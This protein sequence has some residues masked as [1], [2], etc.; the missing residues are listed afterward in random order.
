MITIESLYFSYTDG[1]PWV[2]ADLDLH[3]ASG[4]YISVVGENGSG[5]TTLMRLILGFLRPNHGTVAIDNETV[6]YVPQRQEDENRGFP[7]TV[8]ELMTSFRKIRKLPA[9]AVTPALEA[10]GMAHTR[11][12]RVGDLSGGQHQ[13]IKIA[14]ALLGRPQ[15]LIL[16]E[17]STGIDPGSQK[18]IYGLLNRLNRERG[19]T[20]LSVEHNLDA[21]IANSTAIYHLANGHGHLCSPTQFLQEMKTPGFLAAQADTG[22]SPGPTD[23]SSQTGASADRSADRPADRTADRTGTPADR[24]DDRS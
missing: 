12:R 21:A 5:K 7:I 20:I 2:L 19:I 24:P 6:G 10:V 17:P 1:P 14:R 16:D 13:K 8:G 22:K 9:E 23:A 11:H 18:E 4:D 15:L 3:V